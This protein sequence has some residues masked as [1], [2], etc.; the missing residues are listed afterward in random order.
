VEERAKEA[1]V[2]IEASFKLSAP[3]PDKSDE[4]G[5]NVQKH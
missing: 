1:V 4:V 3:L 5:I 2:T